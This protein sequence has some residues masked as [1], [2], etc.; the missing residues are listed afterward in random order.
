MNWTGQEFLDPASAEALALATCVPDLI[1]WVFENKGI[2][3]V[4]GDMTVGHKTV[5]NWKKVFGHKI[6]LPNTYF[7]YAAWKP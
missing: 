1:R 7:G 6:P 5:N 2:N 4:R 3:I